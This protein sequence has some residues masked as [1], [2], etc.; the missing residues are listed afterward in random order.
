[1]QSWIQGWIGK[2]KQTTSP[3]FLSNLW[4]LMKQFDLIDNWR[5]ETHIHTH[6]KRDYALFSNRHNIFSCI[7]LVLALPSLY[8][9]FTSVNI[10]PRVY[11]DH[12]YVG[13]VWE[14]HSLPYIRGDQTVAL[15]VFMNYS[16]H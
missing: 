7:K 6:K 15:R 1:M 2:N 9:N 3:T 16:S 8:R 4:H 11:S 14:I 12:A 13:V 5:N 10:C